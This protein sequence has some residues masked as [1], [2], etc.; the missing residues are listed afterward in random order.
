MTK[1]CGLGFSSGKVSSS[2]PSWNL[3]IIAM[4]RSEDVVLHLAYHEHHSER[5]ARPL[6]VPD[7]TA[8]L[9]FVFALKQSFDRELHRPELLIPPDDL[10]GLAFVIRGEQGERADEV[11]EVVLIQHP[12]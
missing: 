6:G 8:A 1:M 5:F 10:D 7:N 11:E 2:S 9:L 4:T 3:W 12:G